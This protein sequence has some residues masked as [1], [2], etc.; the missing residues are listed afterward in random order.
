MLA[1]RI[2][3]NDGCRVAYEQSD[4]TEQDALAHAGHVPA[5]IVHSAVGHG[6]RIISELQCQWRIHAG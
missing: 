2:G 5:G 6:F 1:L 4:G 3:Q